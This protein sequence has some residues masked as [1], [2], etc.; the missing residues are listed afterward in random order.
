MRGDRKGRLKW[1]TTLVLGLFLVA[2]VG[3]ISAQRKAKHGAS[4]GNPNWGGSAQLQQTALKAGYASGIVEGRSDRQRGERF[5]FKDENDY[6]SATK[7]YTPDLGD[8]SLYQRY[9]RSGFEN[10]YREGWNGY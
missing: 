5:N 10:G 1:V 4:K 2:S 7:D 3:S 8:K 6:K 9:F